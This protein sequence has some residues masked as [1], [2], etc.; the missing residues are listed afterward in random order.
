MKT[1]ILSVI[2]TFGISLFLGTSSVWATRASLSCTPSSGTYSV[3]DSITVEY[4]LDTRTYP[5]YGADL[6]MTCDAGLLEAVGTQSTAVTS[7]TNWTSIATNTID[8]ALGKIHLDYGSSQAAYTGTTTLGK[9]TFKAKQSGQ[10][11][12]KYTFFQTYDDTTPG[13]VK[14]WG[15]KD[16]V[17][18]SNILTD[19]TNCVFVISPS[20]VTSTP[21]PS[22]TSGPTSATTPRPTVSQLPNSG[23]TETTFA[24]ILIAVIIIGMGIAIPVAT[25]QR[26]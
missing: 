1:K 21:G 18:L 14:V 13:I 7:V 8:A 12:C 15:K 11:E 24:L 19:V 22:V 26:R 9:A 4:V 2:I 6:V 23:N 5:V 3:G 25:S 16:N 17:T 20:Q 10:A